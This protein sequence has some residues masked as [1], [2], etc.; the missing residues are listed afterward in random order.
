MTYAHLNKK[1][2]ST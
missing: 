1:F 2:V